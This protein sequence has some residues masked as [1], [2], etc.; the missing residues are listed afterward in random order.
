MQETEREQGQKQAR[1]L[2]RFS[3]GRRLF[4]G[5]MTG[6]VYL[7]LR[8]RVEWEDE[9]LKER[10]KTE[11]VVFVCNH[12][13]L[14]DGVFAAAV[15]HRFSPYVLV[16]RKWYDRPGIG[17]MIRW[18]RSIP[19]DLGGMDADWFQSGVQALRE[20]HS[21]IIFPEG[22]LAREGRMKPFKPGAGLAAA[23]AGVPVVP[24]AIHGR[25]RLFFGRRQRMR[26]GAPLS[27]RC[28]AEMRHSRF[29]RQVIDQAQGD[30]RRL[31][32]ELIAAYGDCGTY[33]QETFGDR[34]EA[35]DRAPLLK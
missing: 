6:L 31:Y 19:I 32:G 16:T 18:T 5:L 14:F 15:L 1:T 30:V 27:G 33:S 29:A 9:T 28:P 35:A 4:Q 13:H 20:G 7:A 23:A 21:L 8:P 12:T 25:Y 24:V 3:W 34:E 2:P 10:A 11:P 26:V 22:G 17:R